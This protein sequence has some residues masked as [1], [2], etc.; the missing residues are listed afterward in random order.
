MRPKVDEEKCTGC[1][2][3]VN[4]CPKTFKIGE[5]GKAEVIGEDTCGKECDCQ[6]AKDSCPVQAITLEE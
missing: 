5:D 2:I 1:G 6:A 3:C 4:L